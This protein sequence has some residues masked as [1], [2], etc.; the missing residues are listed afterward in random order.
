MSRE[1]PVTTRQPVVILET[2]ARATLTSTSSSIQVNVSLSVCLPALSPP[3][4]PRSTSNLLIS[5]VLP[6]P[7]EVA[8]YSLLLCYLLLVPFS[9]S[10]TRFVPL[11]SSMPGQ[12]FFHQSPFTRVS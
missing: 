7:R 6:M 4:A 10:V 9:Y 8:A 5:L 2:E 1:P 12:H 3:P 11:I